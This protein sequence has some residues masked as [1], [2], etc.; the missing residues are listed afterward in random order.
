M[1]WKINH[2]SVASLAYK[3]ALQMRAASCTCLPCALI[4][5]GIIDMP[6]SRLRRSMQLIESDELVQMKLGASEDALGHA[7]RTAEAM[8]LELQSAHAQ[9]DSLRGQLDDL[10]SAAAQSTEC[11]RLEME[12]MAGK[13]SQLEHRLQEERAS[14]KTRV[15]F[16]G[17]ENEGLAKNADGL[18]SLANLECTMTRS[19]WQ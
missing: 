3:A 5:A 1:T 17:V 6:L 8:R 14:A 19:E 13:I 10:Q 4:S 18:L 16:P 9:H 7:Q 15:L 11:A 2:P 12:R